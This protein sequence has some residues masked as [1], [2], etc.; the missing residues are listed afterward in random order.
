MTVE[1][2]EA[3]KYFNSSVYHNEEWQNADEDSKKRALQNALNILSRQYR[4]REIPIV[5]VFEQA[6]W[7]MKIS[8]ARK[9]A[10][11][12]VVSYSV[13]GITVSLSQVDRSIAPSVIQILGRRTGRSESG[14]L[15]YILSN[16][17]Y[18][19]KPKGGMSQ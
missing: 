3:D 17:E 5:A 13:D 14:R 9:Q 2:S 12:G 8:E 4:N 7:L 1:L 18:I 10:E 19:R 15:G 11:H 16:G 6:L